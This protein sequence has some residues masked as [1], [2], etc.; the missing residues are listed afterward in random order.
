MS[1]LN[2]QKSLSLKQSLLNSPVI[3]SKEGNVKIKQSEVV[4]V[5]EE[6]KNSLKQENLVIEHS[7][8]KSDSN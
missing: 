5:P 3:K 7:P 6:L 1:P 4:S 8:I 2:S